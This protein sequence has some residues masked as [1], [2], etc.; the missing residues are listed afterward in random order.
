MVRVSFG[1]GITSADPVLIDAEDTITAKD[2]IQARVLDRY[3]RGGMLEE[4]HDVPKIDD[5]VG[6]SVLD[7]DDGIQD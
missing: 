1:K 4:V 6:Y 5:T 7:E 2:E 3:L